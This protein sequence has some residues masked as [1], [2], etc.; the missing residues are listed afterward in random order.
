MLQHGEAAGWPAGSGGSLPNS[1]CSTAL[2]SCP[3]TTE[4]PLHV[5]CSTICHLGSSS[6]YHGL[7]SCWFMCGRNIVSSSCILPVSFL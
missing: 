4:Q 7:L 2:W 3:W 6:S 1:V 5:R